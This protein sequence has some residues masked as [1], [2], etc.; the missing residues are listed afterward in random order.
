LGFGNLYLHTERGVMSAV[1]LGLLS[2]M[3]GCLLVGPP[4]SLVIVFSAPVKSLS[5]GIITSLLVWI[6]S[7]QLLRAVE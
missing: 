5:L 2:P 7:R 3:L 6:T 4:W 1:Y